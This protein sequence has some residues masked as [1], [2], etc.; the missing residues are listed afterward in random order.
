[1]GGIESR[2]VSSSDATGL[3]DAETAR[4][5]P[6]TEIAREIGR[7]AMERSTMG[8]GRIYAEAERISAA[9]EQIRAETARI[10]ADTEI[11]QAIGR[12]KLRRIAAETKR[13][14]AD[15]EGV[16]LHTRVHHATSAS[17]ATA[18]GASLLLAAGLLLDVFVHDS[19]FFMK[20]HML[21]RFRIGRPSPGLA[22]SVRRPVMRPAL[23]VV[24]QTPTLLVG[25]SGIGKSE[26]LVQVARNAEAKCPRWD[27]S[28]C[29]PLVFWPLRGEPAGVLRPPD[30]AGAARV[31]P[32]LGL[33]SAAARLFREVGL[34][35]RG[36]H[37]GGLLARIS[38]VL[39]RLRGDSVDAEL[40]LEYRTCDRLMLCL[41]VLFDDVFPQLYAA[42][43]AE[44][45]SPHDAAAVFVVDELH[46]LVE[47]ERLGPAGG[48]RLFRLIVSKFITC[49]V[50]A[51]IVHCVAAASSSDIIRDLNGS[52]F[53]QEKRWAVFNV[54]DPPPDTS[55]AALV[56]AGF[57]DIDARRFVDFCGTR[58]RW[59]MHASRMGP[60][61]LILSEY[62]STIQISALASF[63]Q[64]LDVVGAFS[65]RAGLVSICRVLDAVAATG[66]PPPDDLAP[67]RGSYIPFPL[68]AGQLAPVLFLRPGHRLCFQSKVHRDLWLRHSSALRSVAFASL[69]RA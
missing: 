12:A 11:A 15:M 34:P 50:G 9:T 33:P 20:W 6:G 36:S 23:P 54:T 1:M 43:I 64:V 14:A 46:D 30:K 57:N 68:S 22:A 66:W 51:G 18:F 24:G 56:E 25:S 49:G 26:I 13:I 38:E 35:A 42:R 28:G 4:V 16:K 5:V 19:R 40:R 32:S 17:K 41:E 52:G 10:V 39:F 45:M 67:A 29:R 31:Q 27:K 58:L 62:E 61:G 21:R 60:Q 8:H 69:P 59:V 2:F 7:V 53:A 63:R 47:N 37:V 44:G 3:K 55:I 65:G 48:S